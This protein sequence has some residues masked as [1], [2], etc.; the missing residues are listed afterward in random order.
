MR[1]RLDYDKCQYVT[2]INICYIVV[3]TS[4]SYCHLY[5][6]TNNK[7]IENYKEVIVLLDFF[8]NVYIYIYIYIYIVMML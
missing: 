8:N 2:N 6:Y 3:L 7:L 1:D 4:A 5:I